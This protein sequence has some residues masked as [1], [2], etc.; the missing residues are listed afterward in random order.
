MGSHQDFLPLIQNY[1]DRFHFV[2]L[3]LPGHGQSVN[4]QRYVFD[5]VFDTLKEITEQYGTA[6]HLMGYSLG[7]R[8]A[9]YASLENKKLTQHLIL[10][11]AS[12][13]FESEEARR[14]RTEADK[15][16]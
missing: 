14:L 13:G 4:L 8:T 6:K 5:E 15:K 10:V 12:P 16:W 1:N 3:D 7:G 11:S 9:L 2:L